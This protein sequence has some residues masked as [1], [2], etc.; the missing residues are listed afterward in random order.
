[1][2][3]W[4]RRIVLGAVA[5]AIVLALVWAV[6]RRGW[7]F[8][9]W[10]AGVITV[11]GMAGGLV[12]RT[13]GSTEDGPAPAAGHDESLNIAG[14]DVR[15]DNRRYNY[16]IQLPGTR[17]GGGTRV[18]DKAVTITL[19]AA[20]AA[21]AAVVVVAGLYILHPAG[22]FAR[23]RGGVNI[24]H[25]RGSPVAGRPPRGA[26]CSQLPTAK[27]CF[28]P[29]KGVFWVKDLPPGDADHAAVYWSS[30][31][32][33]L[34]GQ[35]HDKGGSKDPWVTCV[36]ASIL[37]HHQRDVTFFAAVVNGGEI[38]DRGP[39]VTSARGRTATSPPP[40]APSG[41]PGPGG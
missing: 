1:M 27:A 18:P 12:K 40:S 33:P 11:L 20:V 5:L 31:T 30:K 28:D 14:Q 21:A 3:T 26:P 4:V 16:N 13:L 38:V 39:M 23:H 15:V 35:C 9:S 7:E 29:E 19:A 2:A 25:P 24:P 8:A 22:L 6:M 10:L 32:G 34:H 36:F 41:G 37:S 17:T